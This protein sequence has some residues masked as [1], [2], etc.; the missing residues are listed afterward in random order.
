MADFTLHGESVPYV[1]RAFMVQGFVATPDVAGTAEA[2][3]RVADGTNANAS[4]RAA[5]QAY[6]GERMCSHAVVGALWKLMQQLI[7]ESEVELEYVTLHYGVAAVEL[8]SNAA[9]FA[10]VHN[11]GY[12]LDARAVRSYAAQAFS[13]MG[14]M[15]LRNLELDLATSPD[16]DRPMSEWHIGPTVLMRT[17]RLR[18]A[19]RN[20][21][22]SLSTAVQRL[23]AA[24]SDADRGVSI[25]GVAAVRIPLLPSLP[26]PARPARES[27][28]RRKRSSSSDGRA[29]RKHETQA[30][31]PGPEPE[32]ACDESGERGPASAADH[33]AAGISSNGLLIDH[34]PPVDY[35]L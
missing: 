1:Q 26:P 8:P 18:A 34:G 7:S 35:S 19:L 16:L 6:V 2:L 22:G 23:L 24:P 27:G 28:M 3:E 32:A 20:S 31:K 12:A 4:S 13:G 10:V 17:S 21:G 9:Q 33:S 15:L 5:A 30:S 11:D 29:V 14:A 25:G